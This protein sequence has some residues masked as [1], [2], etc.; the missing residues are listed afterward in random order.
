MPPF[1]LEGVAKDVQEPVVE[2][3]LLFDFEL[4]SGFQ[5]FWSGDFDLL[6]TI[7]H[8]VTIYK[9]LL[10][11]ELSLA[12]RDTLELTELSGDVSFRSSRN[13]IIILAANEDYQNRPVDIFFATLKNDVFSNRELFL[14]GRLARID[15]LTEADEPS[16]EVTIQS[17]PSIIRDTSD[18]FYQTSNQQLINPDDTAFDFIE[19]SRTNPQRFGGN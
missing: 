5:Y 16:A 6:V 12:V 8:D 7:E 11:L 19:A 4:D 2:P 17:S 13:E 3:A 15:L 10:K 1:F 14:R 9:P 18:T